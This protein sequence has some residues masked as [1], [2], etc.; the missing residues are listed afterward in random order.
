G[1]G[2]LLDWARPRGLAGAALPVLPLFACA[3]GVLTGILMMR[4]HDPAPRSDRAAPSL[5]DAP[6]PLHGRSVRGLLT[7]LLAWN[8]AVG[9]AGS[10]FSLHMLKN[11]RMGFTLV[12]LHGAGLAAARVLAAPLWGR[13]IDRLGARPV[14][15]TCGFGTSAIPLIWL[16]AT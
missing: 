12:A 6:L 10:F 16:F 15:I 13:L 4:P 7:H 2:L 8:L 9:L 14:L 5:R 3:S 11:L 1:A